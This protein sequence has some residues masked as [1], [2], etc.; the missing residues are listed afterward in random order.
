MDNLS[1][2]I[3]VSS[4]SVRELR[5]KKKCCDVIDYLKNLKSE[6]ICLQ[7]THWVETDLRWLKTLRNGECLINGKSTN[8]RVTILLRYNFEYEIHDI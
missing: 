6:M 7:D 3:T 1:N 2:G 8:S 4:A 5:D